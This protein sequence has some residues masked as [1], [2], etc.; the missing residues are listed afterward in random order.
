[1]KFGCST[2]LYG[3]YSLEEALD[4][5]QRAG[6]EAIELC[7]IPG[8]GD[9]LDLGRE[10]AYYE[11]IRSKVADCGLVIESLGA[12]GGLGNERFDLLLKAARLVG[13]P[14]LACGSGG[15]VGDEESFKAFCGLV[16]SALPALR[17]AGVKLS[18]KP[19]VGTSLKD[20]AMCLRFM[21]EVGDPMVGI[22]LD[23]THI[24]RHGKDPIQAVKDLRDHILTARIRDFKS[25]D[26]GIGPVE[27]QIPGKGMSDV[28]GYL[29]ALCEVPGLKVATVEIVGSKDF[30]LSEV[31]RVVEE[32]IVAL[33]SYL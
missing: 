7:C 15:K 23:N 32:T 16:K 11:D 29:R 18:I 33:K 28:K 25:Q 24:Q 26:L 30:A 12:S 22:N 20:S 1:M 14:C 27:N 31:Q 9:H 3:G 17:Q 13:S 19:H 5:I 4:G 8:M 6:Y 10:D 21:E 2:L